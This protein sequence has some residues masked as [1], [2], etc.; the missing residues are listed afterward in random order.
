MELQEETKPTTGTQEIK[1]ITKN[2]FRG[3]NLKTE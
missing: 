1:N 3:I 2:N